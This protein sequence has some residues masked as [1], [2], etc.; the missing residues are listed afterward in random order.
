MKIFQSWHLSKC[1]RLQTSR[2][3]NAMML[4]PLVTKVGEYNMGR[5]KGMERM[6]KIKE[7]E[8]MEEVRGVDVAIMKIR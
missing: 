6:G 2:Y 5:V 3:T 7:V 4:H 8:R 1:L